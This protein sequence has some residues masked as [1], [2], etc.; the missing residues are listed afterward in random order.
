M[1]CICERSEVAGVSVIQHYYNDCPQHG[2]GTPHARLEWICDR[3]EE[4]VPGNRYS[5]KPPET[6]L[7]NYIDKLKDF[8]RMFADEPCEYKDNCPRFVNLNHYECTNCQAKR[9]LGLVA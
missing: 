5:V 3:I 4:L 1:L 7:F 6:F 8:V 9:V 2:A